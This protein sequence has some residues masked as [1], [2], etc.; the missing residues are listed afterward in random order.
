MAYRHY[1]LCLLLLVYIHCLLSRLLPA[2]LVSVPTP[3]CGELCASTAT[4][5]LCHQ[6]SGWALAGSTGNIAFERCQECR[7][8]VG[9]YAE[10]S[11]EDGNW[12]N[13]R[14]GACI[15][16]WQYGILMGYGF[17][18]PFVLGSLATSQ[19]VDVVDRRSALAAA[20]ALWSGASGI[21]AGVDSFEPLLLSRFLLGVSESFVVPASLSLIT[22]YFDEFSRGSAGS[23]LSAGVCLGAGA[24]SWAVPLAL[25]VGW[26]ASCTLVGSIGAGLAM[27]V[28]LTVREP[29]RERVKA[30]RLGS[31]A[32]GATVVWLLTAAASLRLAASYTIA[33]F[34]PTYYLRANLPGY[35]ASTYAT[36]NAGLVASTG[37]LSALVGG[38]AVDHF[39]HYWR[40]APSVIAAFA[41]LV[42]LFLYLGVFQA[43]TFASSLAFFGMALLVGECWYG[44]MLVQV[45]RAVPPEAQG[46]SITFV[47]SV[48]TIAS[49]LGPA[50]AGVLDPGT[51]AVGRVMLGIIA[52]GVALSAALF[53]LAAWLLEPRPA[54]AAAAPLLPEAP[55]AEA[56]EALEEA[57]ALSPPRLLARA[58]SR[59]VTRKVSVSTPGFA[60][61]LSPGFASLVDG[62][63]ELR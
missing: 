59:Q 33:A 16:H 34:L 46:Q 1:V 63:L 18:V 50:A 62:G 58:L 29:Q 2:F 31:A 43:E 17:A 9:Y 14:D 26:R 48:A 27:L 47:L 39:S 61:V 11:A 13:M 19:L 55:C 57:G 10:T 7:A 35:S 56:P 52:A 36:A 25:R 60:E 6:R 30:H 28:A 22:D 15:A 4:T 12:F 24:A 38:V 23:V 5:P 54:V 42:A 53:A 40:S 49:N 45:Q 51:A 37:L 3:G 41:N 44:L 8:R 21:M 32:V 20:V